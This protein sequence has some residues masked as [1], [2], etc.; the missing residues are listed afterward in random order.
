MI[1]Y[2][3]VGRMFDPSL[4]QEVGKH[5]FQSK[6]LVLVALPIFTYIYIQNSNFPYKYTLSGL[7]FG[8]VVVP[9]SGGV[10]AFVNNI[11]V[12]GFFLLYIMSV[13]ALYRMGFVYYKSL[14]YALGLVVLLL[15]Y[16]YLHFLPI[17]FF[18]SHRNTITIIITLSIIFATLYATIGYIFDKK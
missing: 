1:Q 9:F 8:L 5:I 17:T 18:D 3:M 13:I 10:F 15:L 2:G 14:F 12:I 7:L 16:L 11:S 6:N 4:L